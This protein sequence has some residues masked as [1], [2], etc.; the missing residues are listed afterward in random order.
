MIENEIKQLEKVYELLTEYIV[1]Y[2]FQ[3]VA[4]LFI[5]LVGLWAAKKISKIVFNLLAKN[6][7]DIT[8]NNFIS[9]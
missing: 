5:L 4:A 3:L 9:N 7:V 2:S 6:N 8:L 1:N